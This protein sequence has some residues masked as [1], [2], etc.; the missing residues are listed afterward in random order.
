M[1]E[2]IYLYIYLLPEFI[3]TVTKNFYTDGKQVAIFNCNAYYGDEYLYLYAMKCLKGN[4]TLD[5]RHLYV[6]MFSGGE[7]LTT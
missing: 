7:R 4:C 5:L 1:Y 2:Y 6:C 3:T